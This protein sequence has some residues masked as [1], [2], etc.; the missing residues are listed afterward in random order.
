MNNRNPGREHELAI[1][2]ALA[3]TYGLKNDATISFVKAHPRADFINEL[4]LQI[5]S[6]LNDLIILPTGGCALDIR[7]ATQDDSIGPSDLVIQYSVEK[8][9]YELG[10]SAKFETDVSH[11]PSGRKFLSADQVEKL[12]NTLRKI[13]IPEYIFE[14]TCKYGERIPSSDG[15]D[16]WYRKPSEVT[17]DF[18][19]KIGQI[20]ADR[21]NNS[22][23]LDKK[24]IIANDLSHTKASIPYIVIRIDG[25]P[26][27]VRIVDEDRPKISFLDV[28]NVECVPKEKSQ[29]VYFFNC[30]LR[31]APIARMQ[32]KFN[33][34]ILRVKGGKTIIGDPFGSWN[35]EF[36][37]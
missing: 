12:K 7:D 2:L 25:P 11:N 19:Y 27:K 16:N 6:S 20:V 35:F 36:L 24:R 33:N 21:W 29:Y 8:D 10:I 30:T 28:D 26:Y 37:V 3:L 5:R 23:D 18:I 34:G 17:S 4:A 32:V 1:R 14:M 22:L 9:N 15:R 13:T 31:N